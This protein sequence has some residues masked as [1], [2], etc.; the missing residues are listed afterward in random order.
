VAGGKDAAG[1][2]A[3]LGGG[4]AAAGRDCEPTAGHR[5]STSA[6]SASASRSAIPTAPWRPRSRCHPQP[7]RGRVTGCASARSCA[8]GRHDGGRRAPSVAVGPGRAGGEGRLA[9]V[10]ALRAT[11]GVPVETYDERLSTVTAE[12]SLMEQSLRAP[13]AAVSSTR[14]L[15]P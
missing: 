3:A 2:D 9:E 1:I 5:V 14:W 13:R 12:R 8:N 15:L 10:E 11:L 4:P 6:P 7:R